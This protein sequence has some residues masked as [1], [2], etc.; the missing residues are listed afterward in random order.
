MIFNILLNKNF[1]IYIYSFPIGE[2]PGFPN[3]F[4]YKF[5]NNIFFYPHLYTVIPLAIRTEQNFF[6]QKIL[7]VPDSQVLDFFNLG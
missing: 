2:E 5:N 6:F 4:S 3:F 7:N 1:K